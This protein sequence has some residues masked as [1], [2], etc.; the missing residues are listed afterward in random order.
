MNK[1]PPMWFVLKPTRSGST[2]QSN[3]E[4]P[5]SRETIS[6]MYVS[7]LLSNGVLLWTNERIFPNPNP[8]RSREVQITEWR[9][10]DQIPDPV[11]RRLAAEGPANL[12]LVAPPTIDHV[13]SNHYPPPPSPQVMSQQPPYVPGHPGGPPGP[14]H[15]GI[16]DA[17][18]QGPPTDEPLGAIPQSPNGYPHQPQSPFTPPSSAYPQPHQPS[19]GYR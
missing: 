11:V 9:R 13:D 4:G 6:A 10:I 14:P 1:P 19:P 16:D 8:R 17:I 5:Y 7:G 3:R 18:P 15:G 12:H 2:Q